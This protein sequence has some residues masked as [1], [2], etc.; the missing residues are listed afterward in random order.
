MSGFAVGFILSGL[1]FGLGA[2]AIAQAKNRSFLGYFLLGFFFSL[3]GLLIAIGMPSLSPEQPG[4]NGS[5]EGLDRS[6]TPE[7][8]A[9]RTAASDAG[10]TRIFTRADVEALSDAFKIYLVEQYGITRSAVLGKVIYG[11]ILYDDTESALDAARRSYVEA[12][13]PVWHLQD[14]EREHELAASPTTTA[15]EINRKP[16]KPLDQKYVHLLVAA[17]VAFTLFIVLVT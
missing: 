15:S 5:G 1:R 8:V 11:D 12:V 17:L 2:G 7:S 16:S 10:V 6:P 9:I 13:S 14:M 4:M 3:V